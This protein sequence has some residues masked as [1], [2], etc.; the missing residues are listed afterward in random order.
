MEKWFFNPGVGLKSKNGRKD[1]LGVVEIASEKGKQAVVSKKKRK[2][3]TRTLGKHK[4]RVPW[5]SLPHDAAM[6]S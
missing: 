1:G 6:T 4:A 2:S 5:N 3:Q